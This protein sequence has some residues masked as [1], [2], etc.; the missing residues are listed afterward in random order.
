MGQCQHTSSAPFLLLLLFCVAQHLT[1]ASPVVNEREGSGSSNAT[2]S[3]GAPQPSVVQTK[4]EPTVEQGEVGAP[5]TPSEEEDELFKDVDPKTLAAVLLE[6]LNHQGDEKKI[7]RESE[8]EEV[9]KGEEEKEIQGADRDRDG[10]QEL[11]LVMAAAVAQDKENQE[12]ENE[13]K[14]EEERLTEKVKS[15]TTSQTMPVKSQPEQEVIKEE[16]EKEEEEQL[17]PQEVKNLQTM[18]E[19]L[20]HYSTANK[21]EWDLAGHRES[22]G[23]Y[24]GMDQ[25]F[26]DN[27]INPKPK[28]YK[29]ALSKKKLKWQEEQKKKKQPLFRGGNFMD[30]FDTNSQEEDDDDN[31]DQE[32]E[33]LSPEEEEARAKAEQE[34]VRRQAAE[35]QR[36]KAEE[37][38]LADIASDMLLQYMIKP[39][40]KQNQV[41][42]K[43]VS[44]GNNVE[45][46]KRSDEEDD[47]NDEDDI[48]PQT[49]DKLIEISSKLHLP[50]DD[51][52]DIIS[53][54]EK[55]KRKDTPENLPWH[56]P[57]ASP[58]APAPA[59]INTQPKQPTQLS[60]PSK[61][62]FQDKTLV[63]QNKQ[64]L[65]PKP[66]K[67]FWTYPA[68]PFYQKPYPGY[69]PIYFPP[70]KP[71]PR[72]YT[73]PT[74][75]FSNLFG[76]T[77]DYDFD[78]SP[79]RRLR[80]WNQPAFRQNLYVPNYILPNPRTFKPVPVP[81]PKPRSPPRRHPSFYYPPAAPLIPRDEDYFT[82][83]GQQPNSDQDLENFIEKVFLKRPRLFQ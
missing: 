60:R 11:E 67:Q 24:T 57:L 70:P 49:I 80:P 76:N 14:K 48:D 63:K 61:T 42:T 26:L 41:Q 74:L 46:D 2:S 83:M 12:R 79:K 82:P 35:A 45:E 33:M 59:P 5:Q 3:P 30:D 18:L 8:K 64:D 58:P 34:E 65:W 15:R 73:K 23:S 62:W 13:R 40:G 38:K 43:K 22:R 69:Y 52:V 77:M 20:Q 17:S 55:K 66:Q 54:V 1:V 53:D 4:K 28:G 44:L 72:Y 10:R 68:Y 32:E 50:A 75:S 25:E 21:R 71:K 36:A 16:K 39:D 81:M 31:K 51:V 78:F 27:E 47:T 37:E 7:S 19:E 6:A 9:E 56:R 29:L